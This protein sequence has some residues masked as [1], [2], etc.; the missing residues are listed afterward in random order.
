MK[1]TIVKSVIS[2][3]FLIVVAFIGVHYN[4]SSD[5]QKTYSQ[6]KSESQITNAE[7][8][9]VPENKRNESKQTSYS[10]P[11][12]NDKRKK[13]EK[14]SAITPDNKNNNTSEADIKQ[15]REENNNDNK[16]VKAGSSVE[17]S[18]TKEEDTSKRNANKHYGFTKDGIFYIHK[19]LIPSSNSN[20]NLYLCY[21]RNHWSIS[22]SKMQFDGEYYYYQSKLSQLTEKQQYCFYCNEIGMW[23]PQYLLDEG[24]PLINNND[25]KWN[26]KKDGHNFNT[27]PQDYYPGKRN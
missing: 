13:Q 27:V 19:S 3:I 11:I 15:V 21:N 20:D 5:T 7:M 12:K 4:S 8:Q 25:V 2:G 10:P 1:K 6:P 14:V 26:G 16:N 24:S 22:E 17:E 18:D 9:S 23:L